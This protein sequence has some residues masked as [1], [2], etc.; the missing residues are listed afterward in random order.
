MNLGRKGIKQ[1]KKEEHKYMTICLLE[2]GFQS[3]LFWRLMPTPTKENENL[4][5]CKCLLIMY[6]HK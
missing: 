5:F 6:A 3:L 4:K 2:F 1:I